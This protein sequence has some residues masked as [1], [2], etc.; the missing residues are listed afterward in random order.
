MIY[1]KHYKIDEA[2]ALIP[3]LKGKLIVIRNLALRLKA[4][5]YD[6]YK[7]DY[8]PG[9]H[10]G[11]QKEF[12]QDYQKLR[13]LVTDIYNLGIE[14]K[15][16]EQGLIDFPA[17]RHNGEEVFLCWKMDENDIEFWHRIDDG[18]LGRHHIDEF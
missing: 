5:G 13:D 16:I 18:F 6:I 9:F 3:L 17:V 14:I 8:R 12:P 11:T 7:A 10:P 1:K 2:R 15:G 4:T